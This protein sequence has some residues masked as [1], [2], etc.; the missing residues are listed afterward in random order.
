MA[1]SP[2]LDLRQA[3]T[4]VMTPQ[5]Q[6]AIKLLQLSQLDLAAYVDQELIENPLLERVDDESRPD[7]VAA[8]T[9]ETGGE[10]AFD[11]DA[12]PEPADTTELTA[13]ETMPDSDAPLDTDYE[14][15]WTNDD[16]PSPVEM[17][18]PAGGDGAFES[19]GAGGRR[20]FGDPEFGVENT[21]SESTTLRQHLIDQ[22]NVDIE[23][24]ADRI[25]GQLLIEYVDDAGYMTTPTVEI[26]LQLG[27]DAARVDA[28]LDRLQRFD[29]AGVCARSVT[30]CFA[31]QL[32]ER[33][34]LDPAMQALIEHL[35]L[36]ASHNLPALM[37]ICGVDRQD[38]VDM[39]AELKALNP[40]P[41]ATFE[42]SVSQWI[43]P[44]VLMRA[45][46]GG[47]WAIE[48]NTEVLPRVLVNT[49]Y[50]AE[51]IRQANG[52]TDREYLTERLHAA[53]WLVKSLHQRATTILKVATEIVRQQ[54]EFFRKGINHLRPLVLRDIAE[55]I[56]MHE[57]TVSRV[58]NNKYIATPRGIFEMKYFFTTSIA[59]AVGGDAH[60]SEAVRH[61]I[62]ALIDEES[63]GKI[64]S[65]DKIVD[66]LR[67]DGVEIARRTVAKYRDA[68]HIPSS[69]RRRRLKSVNAQ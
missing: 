14:N 67:D 39:I 1:L 3:Q 58:T 64:L 63:P 66:I 57:S 12:E 60:S 52:S 28:V 59:N 41:G 21:L 46:S 69:V 61:R 19:W 51:I 29:P 18:A 30:E 33:N 65:D 10:E 56:E 44:D 35:E 40:R 8:D 50:Y 48:L 37:K 16:A 5:L 38:L 6:Q 25:I 15:V 17:A 55:A 24:P 54:D 43:T 4:L 49:T 20:D 62:K 22:L 42:E 45:T 26:A 47:G 36:L 7:D 34:R 68:M 11:G 2:R 9:N 23:D 53:N 13:R 32:A 31:L 27:C